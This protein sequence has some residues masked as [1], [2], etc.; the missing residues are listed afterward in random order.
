M[1]SKA[2]RSA[3]F[4]AAKQEFLDDFDEHVRVSIIR[5]HKSAAM[6]SRTT[7]SVTHE[8][9]MIELLGGKAGTEVLDNLKLV[10][11]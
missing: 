5:L 1:D 4:D 2:R 10:K 11:K 3:E 9:Q 6:E 8:V 7:R